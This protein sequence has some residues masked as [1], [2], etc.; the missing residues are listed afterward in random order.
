MIN[1]LL[2][3]KITGQK[4]VEYESIEAEFPKPLCSGSDHLLR[5]ALVDQFG[6]EAYGCATVVL[7]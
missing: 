3:E 1:Q 4:K 6:L 5:Y 2:P 7:A